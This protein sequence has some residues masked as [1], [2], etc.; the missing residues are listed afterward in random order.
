MPNRQRYLRTAI[1]NIQELTG[2]TPMS[3]HVIALPQLNIKVYHGFKVFWFHSNKTPTTS[4]QTNIQAPD[5]KSAQKAIADC[6]SNRR[7]S[8]KP[9][10][11]SIEP[12]SPWGK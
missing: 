5:N 7:Q 1:I 3:S 2:G 8:K 10:H 9:R 4:R 6:K 11:S 12:P